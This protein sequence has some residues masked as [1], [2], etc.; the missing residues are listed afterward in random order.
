MIF[1]G[2]MIRVG[3]GPNMVAEL[4][5]LAVPPSTFGLSQDKDAGLPTMKLYSVF[6]CMGE[7]VL[8]DHGEPAGHYFGRDVN[9]MWTTGS[10]WVTREE[11]EVINAAA[12]AERRG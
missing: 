2:R 9:S 4:T 1:Q 3:F 7:R 12:R 11:A 5:K 8:Q 10:S 6:D